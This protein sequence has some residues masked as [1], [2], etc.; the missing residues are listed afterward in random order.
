MRMMS[1][2][3]EV[4]VTKGRSSWPEAGRVRPKTFVR[5]NSRRELSKFPEE[6]DHLTTGYS[7]CHWEVLRTL[8]FQSVCNLAQF[9]GL[10]RAL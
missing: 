7:L 2:A 8:F 6:I 5:S 10:V 1:A 9:V 4:S 3:G